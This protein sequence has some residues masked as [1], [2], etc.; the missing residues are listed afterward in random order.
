MT[1]QEN[2][3]F[4]YEIS[5]CFKE[6]SGDLKNVTKHFTAKDVEDAVDQAK[7]YFVKIAPYRELQDFLFS[8]PKLVTTTTQESPTTFVQ[9]NMDNAIGSQ[10]RAVYA[11]KF[12][13]A[14]TDINVVGTIGNNNTVVQTISRGQKSNVVVQ[15][16]VGDNNQNIAVV[17]GG[18]VIGSYIGDFKL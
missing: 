17:D 12:D 7:V 11:G 4:V 6:V 2:N 9:V 1:T 5:A 13:I 14:A 10:V 8:S 18:T 15:S 16:A 3:T